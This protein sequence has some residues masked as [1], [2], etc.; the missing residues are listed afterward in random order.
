MVYAVSYTDLFIFLL[1]LYY[2]F[3]NVTRRIRIKTIAIIIHTPHGFTS[4]QLQP[5]G[6]KDRIYKY[7]SVLNRN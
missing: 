5:S 7:V 2:S 6:A 1:L 3:D 4:C